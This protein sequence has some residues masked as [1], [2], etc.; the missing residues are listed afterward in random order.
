MGY[1]LNFNPHIYGKYK[2]PDGSEYEG[3]Y[4][5]GKHH[6][7]GKLINKELCFEGIWSQNVPVKGIE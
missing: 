7:K 6:G 3:E 2:Y 4:L 1:S 5:L